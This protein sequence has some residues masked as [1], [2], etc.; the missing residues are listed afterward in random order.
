MI[1]KVSPSLSGPCQRCTSVPQSVEAVIFISK[2]PGS[3]LGICTC[4]M[5]SGL[6]CSVM[7][8]ARQVSILDPLLG[9]GR[10]VRRL[11]RFEL[12]ERLE[13]LQFT[14]A[15]CKRSLRCARARRL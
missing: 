7:T 9:A 3:S 12:L 14:A 15:V 1:G 11:E 5:G 8:A 13:L 6:L 4:S 2:E 10:R